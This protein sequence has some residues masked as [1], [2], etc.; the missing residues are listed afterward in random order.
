VTRSLRAL[1]LHFPFLAGD[2]DL[3]GRVAAALDDLSPAAV[4]ETGDDDRP[5][6]RIFPADQSQLDVMA[7]MLAAAFGPSGCR[8]ETVDV[9]DEDWAARTQANLTRVAVG[10]LIVSPPWDVPEALPPGSHLVVIQPSMGFGTGHHETTRLCLRLLQDVDLEGRRVVD[11]GTGSGVLAMAAHLLGAREVEGLDVDEDALVS[12]RESLA[13]NGLTER[14]ALRRADL[15]TD[16]IE[17]ADVVLANLT[18]ALLVAQA[19]LLV[20]LARRGGRLVLSGFQCAETDAVQSAFGST[21]TLARV[22]EGDWE[23]LLLRIP[24]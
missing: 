16:R 21:T 23:A 7:S 8:L 20:G 15:R 11:L 18:G 22:G 17:P 24:T 1:D 6:W 2:G 4:H 10:R 14:I 5:T 3:P 19:P 9:E 12:A 13:L